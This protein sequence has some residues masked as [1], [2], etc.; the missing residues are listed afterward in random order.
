MV[1]MEITFTGKVILYAILFLFGLYIIPLFGWQIMVLRG[2]SMKNP[3]GSVDD[4]HEQKLFYGIALADIIITVPVTL[5][6]IALIF[7]GWR[8]GYYLTGLVSFWFLW[9]N[10][11]TTATSLR[12]E[13]P[14]ISFNWLITYPFGAVL[15]LAYIIWSLVYFQGIFGGLK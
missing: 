10:V 9:T 4:W 12:F 11:M 5:T 13:N 7:A 1:D 3:D 6:G 14:K 8:A 2:R 15:G